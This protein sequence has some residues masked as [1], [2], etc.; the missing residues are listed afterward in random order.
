M[1]T[2]LPAVPGLHRS[3]ESLHAAL[4]DLSPKVH[5]LSPTINPEY[6]PE[7][8]EVA[9]RLVV[10]DPRD[11]GG[12]V[13]KLPGA[14]ADERALSKVALDRIAAAA[15]I[16]WDPIRSGRID[17]ASDPHYCH[18]QAVGYVRDLDGSRRT[19][20]GSKEIDLRE[21]NP[22]LK[23]WTPQRLNEA[24]LHLL[25][26]AESKAKN[27]VVRS[28][29]L[30]QKY[31]VAELAEKPFAVLSLVL[32]GASEDPQL[33]RIAKEKLLDAALSTSR[34]LYG[35]APRLLQVP[36]QPAPPPP[37]ERQPPPPVAL[38]QDPDREPGDESEVQDAV[39]C[40][41]DLA[42]TDGIHMVKCPLGEEY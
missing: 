20:I 1:L 8:H 19:L 37:I 12:E 14:Q 36:E 42:S 4:R 2:R 25:S 13:Y 31:R 23:A 35:T 28:L 41:C 39:T 18:F 16:S 9:V 30:K 27:R 26:M 32:T 34:E 21:G 10:V 22:A 7:F 11:E 24:R 3:V 33:E 15:G 40:E 6:V 29:G 38:A 17:D 5:L